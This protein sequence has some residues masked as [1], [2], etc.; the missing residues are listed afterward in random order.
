MRQVSGEKAEWRS[1]CSV[2]DRDQTFQINHYAGVVTYAAAGFSAKNNDTL[3]ADLVAL[4]GL[5]ADL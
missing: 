2:D 4:L 5:R 1:V 3:P